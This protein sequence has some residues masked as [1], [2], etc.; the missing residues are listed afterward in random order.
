MRMRKAIFFSSSFFLIAT[1][2]TTKKGEGGLVSPAMC[3]NRVLLGMLPTAAPPLVTLVPEPK[4]QD[5]LLTSSHICLPCFFL[6]LRG[7]GGGGGGEE[8]IVFP[9]AAPP[10]VTLVPEPMVITTKVVMLTNLI[11]AM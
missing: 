4:E 8:S 10:L 6:V 9:T 3:G 2:K 5:S 11:I 7:G 1:G